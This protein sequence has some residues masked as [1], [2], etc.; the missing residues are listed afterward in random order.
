MPVCFYSSINKTEYKQTGI[1][2]SF[3][4]LVLYHKSYE[5]NK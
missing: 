1:F 3:F 4:I 5:L 2:N